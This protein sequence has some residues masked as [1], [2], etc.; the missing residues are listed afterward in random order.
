MVISTKTLKYCKNCEKIQ[1]VKN[2]ATPRK[3]KIIE[4]KNQ[5]SSIT[6]RKNKIIE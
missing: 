3:N 4:D 5:I 2:V 6:P 1:I